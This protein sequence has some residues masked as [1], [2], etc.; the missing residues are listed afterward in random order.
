MQNLKILSHRF[1]IFSFILALGLAG[2]QPKPP[3]TEQPAEVTVAPAS[4]A[5]AEP[6]GNAATA[7]QKDILLDPAIAQ[8]ADSLMLAKY[9]YTG[10][11]TLDANGQPQPGLAESWVISDDELDYI[12]TLRSGATF[13]DGTLITPDVV[14]DNFNRWF[15]PKNSLHGDAEYQAWETTFL[16]FLGEKDANDRTK[17]IIDGVQKVDSHTVLLHLSRKE[18]NVLT[19][20]ANPAFSILEPQALALGGYG[21]QGSTI[22]SSGAYT[23]SAWT[24]S[25]LTLS[26]NPSYWGGAPTADLEFI[27]K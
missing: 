7:I 11:V 20:L 3:A 26:P 15:D 13:S 27:W 12:F 2:C 17:S 8:D 25:G 14:V 5:S 6:S 9:L 22:V 21:A 10:L 1:L 24:D 23:V 19:W 4:T 16:G 18:A